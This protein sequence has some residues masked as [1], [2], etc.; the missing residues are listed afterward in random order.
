MQC[1]KYLNEMPAKI[2]VTTWKKT[3]HAVV[4]SLLIIVNYDN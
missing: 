1:L 4:L 3:K 2:L